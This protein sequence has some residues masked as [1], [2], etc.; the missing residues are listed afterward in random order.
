MEV[1]SAD[2]LAA[3]LRI[4]SGLQG[5]PA[6]RI[7]CESALV[8]ET[9]LLS[10]CAPKFRHLRLLSESWA[11]CQSHLCGVL[12]FFREEHS[13]DRYQNFRIDLRAI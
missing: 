10:E 3:C 5:I 12:E 8:R 11:F 7:I 2:I 6:D 4:S 1:C 9:K 13:I